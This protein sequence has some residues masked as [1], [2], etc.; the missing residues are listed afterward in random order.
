VC[1]KGF[2]KEDDLTSHRLVHLTALVSRSS[3][4][5]T[6]PRQNSA[7]EKTSHPV[8]NG[9]TTMTSSRRSRRLNEISIGK[10]S[11]RTTRHKKSTHCQTMCHL[12][13]QIPFVEIAPTASAV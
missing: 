2:T 5:V 9:A 1:D 8:I 10:A 7:A 3:E 13:A 11:V 6:S 4:P 12:S